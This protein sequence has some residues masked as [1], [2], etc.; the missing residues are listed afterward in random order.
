RYR[1]SNPEAPRF[2]THVEGM[3]ANA[4]QL[5]EESKVLANLETESTLV[6][7]INDGFEEYFHDWGRRA[8]ISSTN[9][10][11]H[12]AALADLLERKVVAP[13]V[14]LRKFN[15]GQVEQS[16]QFNHRIVS[17]IRWGL[18]GVAVAAPVAG[19]LLGYRM[20]RRLHNSIWQLSVR[21]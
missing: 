5:L 9:L 15:L 11:A 19:L 20:A 4:H 6:R 12:D 16:D 3:N 13:C 2:H 14:E 21:I 8:E 17:T 18:F 10:P 1:A 7:Q